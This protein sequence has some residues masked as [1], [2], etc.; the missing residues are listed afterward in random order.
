MA[1]VGQN[2][3]VCHH[4]VENENVKNQLV[5][6]EFKIPRLGRL[7]KRRLKS[8]WNCSAIIP[9]RSQCFKPGFHMIAA[10]AEKKFSDRSDHMETTLH[11]YRSDSK[12]TKMH[13]VR[14]RFSRWL[15]TSLRK[16]PF[17]L[18]LRRWGRFAR[19]NVC[20]SVTEIPYWW[21][22]SMFT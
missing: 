3:R 17:L 8:D 13:C 5:K 4:G 15:P 11:S 1:L 12:S 10:I 6:R 9:T 21:R 22:K 16:H 19:R 14:S 7:Q 2:S 18:A 20:D